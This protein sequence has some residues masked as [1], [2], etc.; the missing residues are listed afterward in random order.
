MGSREVSNVMTAGNPVMALPSAGSQCPVTPFQRRVYDVVS[1]IPPG[2]V[3]TYGGVARAVGC[4]CCRA[5]GQALRR[6]PFAP[7]VPCHRV[8]AGDFTLGGFN[9]HRD[10]AEPVRKRRR[11]AKEGVRF[12]AAGRLDDPRRIWEPVTNSNHT[13]LNA[14]NNRKERR[15]KTIEA[16]AK[17]S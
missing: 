3:A 6:N 9:G 11:L 1:A 17:P 10:G 4:R 8:I 5:V 7:Q 2:R 16:L 12:D 14:K 13:K 15:D